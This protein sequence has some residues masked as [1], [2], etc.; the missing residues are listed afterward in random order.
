MT[1]DYMPPQDGCQLCGGKE[2]DHFW[3]CTLHD[4]AGNGAF[5]CPKCRE[6]EARNET[7]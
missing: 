5:N 6:L 1:H 3:T 2:L 7:V 4:V